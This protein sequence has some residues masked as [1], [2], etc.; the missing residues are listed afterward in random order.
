MLGDDARV[1][2]PMIDLPVLGGNHDSTWRSQSSLCHQIPYHLPCNIHKVSSSA[3]EFTNPAICLHIHNSGE[4]CV[5]I[6][7]FG[8]LLRSFAISCACGIHR[9]FNLPPTHSQLRGN[10]CANLHVWQSVEVIC[11]FVC[12]WNLQILQSAFYTFTIP[13]KS[14]CKFASLAIC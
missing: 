9:S 10:L 1:Q 12:M 8:N 6:C 4:I 5:Q 7:K 3:C 14:V 2:T 11:N 13:G